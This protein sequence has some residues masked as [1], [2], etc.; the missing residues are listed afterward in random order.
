MNLF[1]VGSM[2]LTKDE[3]RFHLKYKIDFFHLQNKSQAQRFRF[4]GR[5]KGDP[6][7]PLPPPQKRKKEE[8]LTG[9][10]SHVLSM[11]R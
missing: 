9:V 3:V 11:L 10:V 2:L 4:E 6:S 7:P 8:D 5:Q 1:K